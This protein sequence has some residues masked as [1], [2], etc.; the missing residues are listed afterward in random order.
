MLDIDTWAGERMD[1][2]YLIAHFVGGTVAGW[3][4]LGIILYLDLSGLW[5]LISRSDMWLV[6]SVMLGKAFGMTFGI[7]A[8]ATSV[9]WRGA[10]AGERNAARRSS[11]HG[12]GAPP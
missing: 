12:H 8:T 11:S 5:T 7:A 10:G 1:A 6:A 9:C 3:L 2:R 4:V